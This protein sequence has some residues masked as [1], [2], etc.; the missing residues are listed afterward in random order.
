MEVN[1]EEVRLVAKANRAAQR[2]EYKGVK[3]YIAPVTNEYK[4][5]EGFI[6]YL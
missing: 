4:E 6:F 2:K 1:V 5:E 3:T